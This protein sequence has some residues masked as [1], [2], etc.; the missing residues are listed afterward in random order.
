MPIPA[1][2]LSATIR[3]SAARIR[4]V[5]RNEVD[6]RKQNVANEI[7]ALQQQLVAAAVSQELQLRARA[8]RAAALAE[9]RRVAQ[10]LHDGI[11][12]DLAFIVA[13]GAQM[14][15]ELGDEHPITV[16]ARRALSVSRGTISELSDLS[17]TNA[18]EALEA[19]AL[20]LRGRFGIAITVY[21]HPDVRSRPRLPST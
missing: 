16:A 11:A 17:A 4:P 9:R 6:I 21:A 5:R 19:V 20:E 8:A 15:R 7:A 12:Q 1:R 14:A 18:D 13:H 3:T 10:D 2:I